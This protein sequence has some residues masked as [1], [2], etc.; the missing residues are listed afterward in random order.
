M[1]LIILNSIRSISMMAALVEFCEKY[2]L[3]GQNLKKEIEKDETNEKK[4]WIRKV[5]E[6]KR[7]M[8][9]LIPFVFFEICWWLLAVQH[10]FFRYSLFYLKGINFRG[11]K[12]WRNKFS[13]KLLEGGKKTINDNDYNYD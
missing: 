7:F 11:I 3:E 6:S 5:I 4:K 2:F 1:L 9:I 10:D 8:G 13:R 12:Y